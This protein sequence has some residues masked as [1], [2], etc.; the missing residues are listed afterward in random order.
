ME[1]FH[2][3]YDSLATKQVGYNNLYVIGCIPPSLL[4]LVREAWRGTYPH[5]DFIYEHKFGVKV[6]SVATTL[7]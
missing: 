3:L 4:N 5:M 6:A 1:W 7:S 2:S